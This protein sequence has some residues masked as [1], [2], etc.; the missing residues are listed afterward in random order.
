MKKLLFIIIATY[1]GIL[2][3]QTVP[4]E[5]IAQCQVNPTHCVESY[6]YVKDVNNLLNKYVGTWKGTLDGKNY[7]FNFTKKENMERGLSGIKWDRLIGR[8]KITNQNG[9]IEFDNFNKPNLGD[10]FQPDLK[11]YLMNFVGEKSECI[12]Y[13]NI[14]LRIKSETPNQMSINFWPDRDIVT[15]DCSNFKTTLP[16]NKNIH[17]TKQ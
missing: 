15:Q 6:N 8:L 12:D 3:A 16:V 10:N 5:F 2:N 1:S 11:A 17:L 4:L 7:E 9:T 14:Y 13:G